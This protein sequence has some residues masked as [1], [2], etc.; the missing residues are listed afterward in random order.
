MS[1]A[2]DVSALGVAFSGGGIRSATFNLGVA[3]GLAKRNLW[4]TRL[5]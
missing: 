2:Q 5:S 1:E 3:Q 4:P